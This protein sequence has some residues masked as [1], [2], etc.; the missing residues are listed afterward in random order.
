MRYLSENFKEIQDELIRP[1]MKLYF[2]VGTN[3]FNLVQKADSEIASFDTHVVPEVPPKSA[4]NGNFYAV[5][6]D[7]VPVDDPNRICAPRYPTTM[8]DG[9]SVPWG[10]TIPANA[11]TELWVGNPH[12]R[13]S[14]FILFYSPVK[15]SFA[16][17]HIPDIIKVYKY[18]YS[19]QDF[20][21]EA[22]IDNSEFNKEVIFTPT[23]YTDGLY[24]RIFGLINTQKAGRFQVN[25]ME[26]EEGLKYNPPILPV[27]FENE[28]VSGITISQETDLTSQALPQYDMT[29]EVLDVDEV[30]TPD[31]DAWKNQFN[32]GAKCFFK[33]GYEI[34]EGVDYIP[35]FSGRLTKEPT[36]TFGKITFDVSVDMKEV[37]DGWNISFVSL[38][39]ADLGGNLAQRLFKDYIEEQGLFDS[40]DVFANEDDEEASTTD[41]YGTVADGGEARQLVANA[42]GCF[43]TA[44]VNT[45]DLHNTNFIQYGSPIDYL[46]RYE[47]IQYTL[48]CQN[49]VGKIS[50]MTNENRASDEYVDA[51][52]ETVSF[53][54]PAHES[55]DVNFVIPFYAIAKIE[56]HNYPESV[57]S[58]DGFRGESLNTGGTVTATLRF[59]NTTDSTQYLIS[60]KAKFYK[61][62]PQQYEDTE[63]VDENNTA[64][65]IYTNNNYL[66]T[67]Y[68]T[69]EKANRVAKA[70]SDMS[71]Q[72]E[73][74][75][76]QNFEYEIGDIVRLETQENTFKTCVITGL[77][78][79]FPGTSG[80]AT[81]RRIFAIEDTPEAVIGENGIEF[82][83][84]G[85]VVEINDS[86]S[87]NGEAFVL[88]FYDDEIAEKQ[89]LVVIGGHDSYASEGGSTVYL[90]DNNG[91]RW[92][93]LSVERS[94]SESAPT[95]LPYIELP[96]YTIDDPPI[97]NGIAYGAIV[98]LKKIYEEQGMTAPVDFNCEYIIQ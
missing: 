64:T 87:A 68:Y 39:D 94:T 3:V 95:D 49:K 20:Q 76:I 84:G 6:G 81:L 5:L 15:I 40:Y 80:H 11:N 4:T 47:Q 24:P 9:I 54:V 83:Y 42:L 36:Y 57:F 34:G 59:T 55:V 92:D 41:Y 96:P 45:V 62:S 46:T 98:M 26:I 75:L 52:A 97:D 60:V 53:E 44:G 66:I 16:G 90:Y 73:V 91:H 33:L 43:I 10:I 17:E 70:V 2:E 23:N 86:V 67:N 32:V 69:A 65:E 50:V 13:E 38:A 22:T 27:V 77:Q 61:V 78:Y 48:D 71:D 37:P 82:D 8:P 28:L 29:V 72:Y 25:Y 89:R 1:Q 56:A 19:S 63:V 21:L 93:I 85:G 88:G 74:D 31:S 14:G 51:T 18:N 35:F 12:D 79:K 58:Y 30:Y 7:G